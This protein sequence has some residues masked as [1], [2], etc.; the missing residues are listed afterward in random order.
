[1]ESIVEEPRS[2]LSETGFTLPQG[3][4]EQLQA[5]VQS[6]L[7]V[8]RIPALVQRELIPEIMRSVE[9]TLGRES[10]ACAH[11]VTIESAETILKSRLN[12][13]V[14]GLDVTDRGIAASDR[15]SMLCSSLPEKLGRC[16][17]NELSRSFSEGAVG[18]ARVRQSNRSPETHLT[19]MQ[20]SLSRLPSFRMVGGWFL[21]IVGTVLIFIL[22]HR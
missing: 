11:R 5:R 6:Y 10:S 12:Q 14:G 13:W 18:A 7:R 17:S 20:T 9:L 21:M 8:W 15:M 22:T 3:E 2:T 1:M 19:T 4:R 16:D